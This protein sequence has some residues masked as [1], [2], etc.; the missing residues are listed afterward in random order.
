MKKN[1]PVKSV[2][3]ESELLELFRKSINEQITFKNE[4]TVFEKAKNL[5]I[6]S[7]INNI[8]IV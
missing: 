6:E 7:R 1:I 3:S 4:V 2:V 5:L 8:A